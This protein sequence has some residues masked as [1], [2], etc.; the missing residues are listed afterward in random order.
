[1]RQAYPVCVD[2]HTLLV[3][4]KL[5]THVLTDGF[6]SSPGSALLKIV[7]GS[8]PAYHYDIAT[9]LFSSLSVGETVNSQ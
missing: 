9:A 8:E 4:V 2:G 5:S 3:R 1:M 6:R 7:E